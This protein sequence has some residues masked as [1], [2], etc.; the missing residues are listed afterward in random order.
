MYCYIQD[1]N[2]SCYFKFIIFG[3]ENRNIST[4]IGK[5][6]KRTDFR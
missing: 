5:L 2:G 1:I 6:N 4:A 3:E